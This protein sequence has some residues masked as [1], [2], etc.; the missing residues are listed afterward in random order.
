[1]KRILGLM[2]AVLWL[3]AAHAYDPTNRKEY[4]AKIA[5]AETYYN[6][7]CATVAG[8]KIYKTALEV[9]GVLLMKVRPMR[10]D[11]EL[12]DPNWPGAAFGTEF[13]GDSYIRSFLGYEH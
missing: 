13:Y 7:K 1:M 12:A 8:L 3:G 6:N 2:V 9:E 11:R 5:E 4:L 10:T